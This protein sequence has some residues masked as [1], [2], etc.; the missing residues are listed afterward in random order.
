MKKP[1]NATKRRVSPKVILLRHTPDPEKAVATAAK[2]CY[3]SLDIDDLVESVHEKDQSSFVRKIVSLGHQSVL[4]HASYT[5]LIEGISRVT[6]HQLVRHRVASYSQRSQ[7]Y[8]REEGGLKYVIPPCFK[9]KPQMVLGF[10]DLMERV[11]ELYD[12]WVEAGIQQEDARYIL[13][14][15]A[16]TK[17]T[18]TMNARE[19]RHFFRYRCCQRAQWEI[20]ALAVLMLHKVYMTSPTLFENSGPACITGPCPEGQMSCG[21]SAKVKKAFCN[22]A[23]VAETEL[24]ENLNCLPFY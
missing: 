2:L 1:D 6:T 14:N 20:R 12:R 18:V 5:F 10:E 23:E 21:F 16:E 22:L 15:A 11:Y 17:I 9:D 8:V 3:S 7:R 19:L 4:E 24:L 13:P